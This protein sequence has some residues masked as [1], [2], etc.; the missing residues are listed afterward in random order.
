MWTYLDLIEATG[1]V[2][3]GAP[4]G[5]S[6]VS[7]DSRGVVPGVLFFALAGARCDGHDFVEAALRQG[8]AG[9]VVSR[10]AYPSRAAAWRSCCARHFLIQTD[11]PLAALQRMATWHRRRFSIPVIG[12][13]GSNGKTTTKDMIA[14]ILNRRGPAAATR[15][16]F[17]NHIGLPLSLLSITP[18]HHA[19]VLEIGISK[20]GEMKPLCEMATPTVGL[21]TNVGPAHLAFLASVEGVAREKGALLE[22]AD[23]AVVN[24]DDPHLR[25]WA[26]RLSQTWTYSENGPADVT[27]SGVRPTPEGMAFL[28]H[29]RGKEGGEVGLATFGRHQ[30]CN[31]LAAAASALAAGCTLDAVCEGLAAYRPAAM[32]MEWREVGGVRVLL[33]AY[34]ANPASMK[35]ALGALAEC[36]THGR[37]IAFLGDMLELGTDTPALHFDVGAFAAQCGLHR[38]LAVGVWAGDVVDGARKAGLSDAAGYATLAEAQ[39]ALWAGVRPGDLLLIK[40]SRGMKMETVLAAQTARVS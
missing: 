8:A 32:R 1:G 17:N 2:G 12:V 30:R 6:G 7:I 18:A 28:L 10:A 11:D 14:A 25:P 39:T 33:D 24:L 5:A 36:A 19:A 20:P 13:T 35:A 27:A 9:A 4:A 34:N 22:M 3:A 31:A 16:N 40:G 26:A 37:K 15:G 38:L 23:T 21:V 29:A